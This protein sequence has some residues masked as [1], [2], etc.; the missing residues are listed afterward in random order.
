MS[1]HRKNRARLH[2]QTPSQRKGHG[3]SGPV[4]LPDPPPHPGDDPSH[5]RLCPGEDT[6]S[7]PPGQEGDG[8]A[9]SG[10]D[11][12]RRNAITHGMRCQTVFGDDVAALIDERIVA[13]TAEM[14]PRS[15]YETWAITE[16]ARATVLVEIGGQRLLQDEVRIVNRVA[17]SYWQSD[18]VERANCLAERLG[19][20]PYRTARAARTDQARNRAIA[21]SSQWPGRCCPEQE[22][23]E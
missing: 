12:S 22:F 18:A 14:H 13:F 2:H 19:R 11:R 20:R 7:T 15:H 3:Q 23:F 10:Y 4:R 9:K 8:G 1:R 6:K 16:L 17:G 5:I 21:G